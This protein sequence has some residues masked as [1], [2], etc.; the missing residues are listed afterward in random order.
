MRSKAMK[1]TG[2][3]LRDGVIHAFAADALA[4]DCEGQRL[5]G[6]EIPAEDFARRR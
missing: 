1:T 2:M 6:V 3:A 5:P 4:E